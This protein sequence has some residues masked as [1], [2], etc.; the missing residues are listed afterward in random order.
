MYLR[1]S[2]VKCPHG[3]CSQGSLIPPAV[4]TGK[5]GYLIDWTQA[6]D[7]QVAIYKSLALR[8]T[9][10][11]PRRLG[12]AEGTA[13]VREMM[14]AEMRDEPAPGGWPQ[15]IGGWM[16]LVVWAVRLPLLVI[17]SLFTSCSC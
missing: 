13:I 3:R 14:Q 9:K 8:N 7:V 1:V 6:T 16:A 11:M 2:N 15:G 17:T 10:V 5:Q 12:S 4:Q